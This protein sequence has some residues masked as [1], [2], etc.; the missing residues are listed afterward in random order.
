[1]GGCRCFFICAFVPI[2][3]VSRLVVHLLVL[4]VE[5]KLFTNAKVL[6]FLLSVR[7]SAVLAARAAG[8]PHTFG[9]AAAPTARKPDGLVLQ[10]AP[11]HLRCGRA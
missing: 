8:P 2:Y 9:D 5:A 3:W 11:M 6:F 4:V 7:V 1:M 10:P